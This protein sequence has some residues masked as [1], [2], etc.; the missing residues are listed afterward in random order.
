LPSPRSACDQPAT[1]GLRSLRFCEGYAP[2]LSVSHRTGGNRTGAPRSQQRTWAENDGR[3]PTIALLEST[4]KSLS[5][6][7]L[8]RWTAGGS[9]RLKRPMRPMGGSVRLKRP[10][11]PMGGSVRLKRP[12]RPMGGSVRLKRLI[13]H[14]GQF[15]GCSCRFPASALWSRDLRTVR[16]RRWF[17]C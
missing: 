15:R 14:M 13:S 4:I 9:V 1:Q 3:S 16:G 11:R 7:W 12:M 10:M 5:A 6:A 8:L 2:V 17:P